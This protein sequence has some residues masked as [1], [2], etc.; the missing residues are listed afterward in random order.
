MSLHKLFICTIFLLAAFGLIMVASA[1]GF[2]AQNTFGDSSHLFFRQL[3]LG[4]FLGIGGFF[5][6]YFL[7]TSV[8]RKSAV[9]FLFFC[10]ILLGLV[11]VPSLGVT[12]GGS[13]RWLN[14]GT[15]SFQPSELAK[16][17]VIF[18]SASW[19]ASR[20]KDIRHFAKGFL[21]FLIL[22]APVPFLILAEPNLSNFGIAAFIIFVLLFAAGARLWHIG[23]LG[24]AALCLLGLSIII[25]PTRLSRVA[26]F[27]NPAADPRDTGYQINQS[28]IAIGSGG[29]WGK[30]LGAS[31]QKRGLLPEPSGDAIFAVIA[32][33]LGFAGSVTL[34]A[35]Y[36]LLLS[37]GIIIASRTSDLFSKYVTIGFVSLISAQAFINISAV[38]GLLPLTGVTLPF[39]SY[40]STSLASL[41]T[42]SGVVAG[43]AKR[44]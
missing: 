9:P 7:N 11:F 22:S 25:F 4:F 15:F 40:G 3:V 35:L 13:H 12:H 19:L 42:A 18:Y 38:S 6:F 1:S 32:E 10:I 41:L 14:V 37:E 16:I 29:I 30:G 34:V 24:L 33:E 44:S 27:F 28:L 26:T 2:Q 39:I 21:P 8:V 31:V 17:A 43:I 36:L 20:K 5:A 23:L